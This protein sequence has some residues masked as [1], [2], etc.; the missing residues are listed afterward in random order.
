M[1]RRSRLISGGFGEG[2]TPLS[3][4]NRAVKPLSA[5]GTCPLWDRESRSPPV[6][7]SR[8]PI[9]RPRVVKVRCMPYPETLEI[10]GARLERWRAER[11]LAVIRVMNADD[12]VMRY[13]TRLPDEAGLVTMSH[14]LDE[15]WDTYGFGVWAVHPDGGLPV[16]WVGACHPRWH[17]EFAHEV[18][19][20]WGMTK[21]SWGRG[22]ATNGARAA[23]EACRRD[24]AFPKVIAFIDPGNARSEAVAARLGMR[25]TG[26]SADPRS[27][28]PLQIFTLPLAGAPSSQ[29]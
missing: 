14:R 18:E 19:L 25:V 4:P 7:S 11:H 26:E 20:A 24:L 16:G 15:H 5:D 10:P 1:A 8:P 21:S 17:P 22:F 9:G 28:D 23:I 27:G 6:S 29:T 12:E 13:L 2:E 3:I